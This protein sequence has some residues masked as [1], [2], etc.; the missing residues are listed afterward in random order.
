MVSPHDAAMAGLRRQRLTPG[1]LARL[2]VDGDTMMSDG[3]EE[4]ATNWEAVHKANGDVLV[5]GLGL[6][7]VLVP[8]LSKPEVR[9]V[10][11]L[12]S[13]RHVIALVEDAVRAYVGCLLEC[14]LQVILADVFVWKPWPGAKWDTLYFDVWK[15]ICTDNLPEITKLKRRYAKRLNRDNPNAWMGAWVEERLR[16]QKRREDREAR[17]YGGYFQPDGFKCG[18][19]RGAL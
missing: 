8:M 16:S 2:L 6:G 7:M 12:E 18:G 4:H 3:A 9:R 17:A 10:T 11:V 13:N 1:P 19:M 15:D 14:K 5:A